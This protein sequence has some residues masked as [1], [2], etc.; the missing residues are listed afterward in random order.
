MVTK[1]GPFVFR[2]NTFLEKEV[3]R[4]V[5][6]IGATDKANDREELGVFGTFNAQ[7]HPR[8][9]AVCMSPSNSLIAAVA[10]HRMEEVAVHS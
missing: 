4:R 8:Q 1:S 10:R 9:H 3:S 7:S 6:Q 2:N 5:G